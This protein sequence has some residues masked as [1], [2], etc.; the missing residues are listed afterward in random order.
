MR[1]CLGF[2]IFA[3]FYLSIVLLWVNLL[4]HIGIGFVVVV[5]LLGWAWKN[6]CTVQNICQYNYSHSLLVKY[7]PHSSM[8][9]AF[10][11]RVFRSPEWVATEW[12]PDKIFLLKLWEESIIIGI[13]CRVGSKQEWVMWY[14]PRHT[15]ENHMYHTSF[16]M[17]SVSSCKKGKE[18]CLTRLD[19]PVHVLHV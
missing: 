6:H 19:L 17:V 2:P 14:P 5:N 7:C 10:A 15:S 4:M 12:T 16:R 13:R 1:R 11:C 18:T 3:S 9:V 8:V